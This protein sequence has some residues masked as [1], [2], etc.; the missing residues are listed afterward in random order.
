[1]KLKYLKNKIILGGGWV[2]EM[3]ERAKRYKLPIT[4]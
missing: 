3:V 4:K 1:M 2:G